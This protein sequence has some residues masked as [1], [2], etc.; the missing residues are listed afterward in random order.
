MIEILQ[1]FDLI[2]KFEVNCGSQSIENEYKA[3][4]VNIGLKD[5]SHTKT[6]QTWITY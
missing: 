5:G 1:V 3:Y 4:W 2:A 6:G